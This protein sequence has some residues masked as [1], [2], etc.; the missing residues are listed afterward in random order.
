MVKIRKGQHETMVSMG[1]YENIFK[2]LGYELVE[3]NKRS[4][5]KDE[6]PKIKA[7]VET[8]RRRRKQEEE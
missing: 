7:N 5:Y 2:P 3:E 4:F 6:M 8:S 1:S